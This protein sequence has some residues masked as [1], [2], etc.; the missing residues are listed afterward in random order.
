MA[1][2]MNDSSQESKEMPLSNSMSSFAHSLHTNPCVDV[3]ET[4]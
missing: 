2:L 1:E 3:K 4:K